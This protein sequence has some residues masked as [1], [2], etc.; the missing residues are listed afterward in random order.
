[1]PEVADA[2]V[3]AHRACDAVARRCLPG[4]LPTLRAEAALRAAQAGLVLDGVRLPLDAVRDVARGV[5]PPPA[6]PQ[7]LAV[8]GALRV[9]ADVQRAIVPGEDW[10]PVGQEPLPQRIARWHALA[11]AG[12][13]R[14]EPG[15]L[16]DA[17]QPGDLTGLGPAPVGPPLA[18]RMAGLA[19]L[20]AQPVPQGV[21]GLVVAAVV[22][23][24]LLAMRPFP[25][26]NGVVARAVLR[27]QLTSLGVDRAAVVVPE[28]V[29]AEAP[30][31]Y[32]SAVA[33]YTTGD[34]PRVVGWVRFVASGVRRAADLALDLAEGAGRS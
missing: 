11:A 17:E 6:G 7:G 5:T 15:R 21:S 10:S 20:V 3:E 27:W 16:R 25:T 28:A 31:R 8:A 26:A 12:V 33:G 9:A 23:A 13:G 29:W 2:V 19:T 24:E 34:W 32:L 4:A 1:M 18:R 22:H 30:E 14:G